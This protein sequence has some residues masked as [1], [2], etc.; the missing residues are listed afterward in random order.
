[1]HLKAEKSLEFMS[2]VVK[3]P[4]KRHYANLNCVMYLS[5]ITKQAVKH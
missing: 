1:M 5:V 4:V 2:L 3:M